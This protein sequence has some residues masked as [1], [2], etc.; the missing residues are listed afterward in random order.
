MAIEKLEAACRRAFVERTKLARG[1]FSQ[2]E[3]CK[4]PDVVLRNTDSACHIFELH[5]TFVEC[6]G[7]I[8]PKTILDMKKENESVYL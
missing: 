6:C 3:T 8:G 7:E 4:F 1:P 2:S 5:G